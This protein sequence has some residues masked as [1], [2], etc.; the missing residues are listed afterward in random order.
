M[1]GVAT[2]H[3][4]WSGKWRSPFQPSELVSQIRREAGQNTSPVEARSV[5]TLSAA[6]LQEAAS[7]LACS[8]DDNPLFRLAFPRSDWRRQILLALFIT[9]LKDAIRFG[10]VEMAYTHQIV[11]VVIWYPPSRYPMSTLRILRLLPEYLCIVAANPLGILKLFRVQI[12]LERYRPK[13]PHCHGCFLCARPG[14]LVGGLLIRRVLNELDQ[15]GLP[16]YLETQESRCPNLYGRFG[17]KL[18]QNGFETLPHGPLT[19]TMWRDAR[20]IR[21]LSGGQTR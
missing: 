20:S 9:I 10:R 21:P 14:N 5:T 8:F 2:L 6:E 16:I 1:L 13:Q 4:P 3:P 7:L 15:L 11:G 17:F 12:A 19:W 18:S